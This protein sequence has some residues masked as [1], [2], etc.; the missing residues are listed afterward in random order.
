M[1]VND[2]RIAAANARRMRAAVQRVEQTP[3]DFSPGRRQ[4]RVGGSAVV[5]WCQL[6]T[7]LNP[8]TGTWPTLTPTSV[9]VNVYV[10]SS[11]GLTQ[12]GTAGVKVYNFRNVTWAG[13]KTTRVE[14]NG[15][16]WEI[17]DQDC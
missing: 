14:F 9:T 10:G 5:G 1:N 4:P 11:T 3:H 2:R 8:A 12:V 13:S 16:V 7:T 15:A 17:M 6:A